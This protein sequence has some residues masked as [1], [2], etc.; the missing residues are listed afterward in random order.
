[1]DVHDSPHDGESGFGLIMEVI[2]LVVDPGILIGVSW[3]VNLTKGWRVD[4]VL[5]CIEES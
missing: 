5:G 2:E 4:V 1:L 3:V